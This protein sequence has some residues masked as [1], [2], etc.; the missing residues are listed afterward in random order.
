MSHGLRSVRPEDSFRRSPVVMNGGR[1][2]LLLAELCDGDEDVTALRLGQVCQRVT[3]MTGA[4]IMLM[5]GELPLGSVGA[6]GEVSELIESL[7]YTLGEGPCV[8]AHRLG[9]PVLEPDL[10]HPAEARWLAFTAPAVEAGVRAIF[11]FPLTVGSLRMGAM[12]LFADRPG[13]LTDDQHA[14]ALVMADIAAQAVLSMQAGASPGMVAAELEAGSNFQFV[15]HQAA[16]MVSAQLEIGIAQALIRLRA[17]A[18]GHERLLAD[19]AADVVGR[20]LRFDA[21]DD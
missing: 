14:N 8:D 16:G 12:N 5:S 4:G 17:H 13:S 11:G 3:D 7:Q 18:F 10:A 6:T 21:R 9:R 20:R 2:S 1:R 19:V 15:V